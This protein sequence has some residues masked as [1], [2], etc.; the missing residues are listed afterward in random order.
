MLFLKIDLSFFSTRKEVP[1][2]IELPFIQDANEDS[3]LFATLGSKIA[4]T[5][6]LFTLLDESRENARCAAFLPMSDGLGR[7]SICVEIAYS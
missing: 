2:A 3:T 1:L 4:S 7:S 5:E 6:Q